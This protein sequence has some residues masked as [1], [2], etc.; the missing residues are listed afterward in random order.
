MNNSTVKKFSALNV[1]FIFFVSLF[2]LIDVTPAIA[3]SS[4]SYSNG[5]DVS[6]DVVRINDGVIVESKNNIIADA[7]TF[8]VFTEFSAL[9]NISKAVI[10][11]SLKGRQSGDAVANSV[12]FSNL[13]SDNTF[14]VF[15]DL[16]TFTSHPFDCGN[17]H[18]RVE[19]QF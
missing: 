18:F 17:A 1:F 9:K 7:N 8:F 10:E 15:L 3:F 11:V 13:T 19:R 2:S 6:I 16:P 14:F 5:F 12:T 4:D